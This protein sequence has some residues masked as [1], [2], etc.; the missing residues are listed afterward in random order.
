MRPNCEH[1]Y[2]ACFEWKQGSVSN[3]EYVAWKE[4][5]AGYMKICIADISGS[6]AAPF[7]GSLPLGS[8]CR[9]S[10]ER[11][12]LFHR[13]DHHGSPVGQD[14]GHALHDLGRVVAR[15]DNCIPA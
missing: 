12:S 2:L 14:F 15:A 3:W 1:A 5:E 10:P 4:S 8:S 13:L 6:Y 7:R 9:S 11:G